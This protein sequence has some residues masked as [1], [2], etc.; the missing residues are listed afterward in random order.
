[1]YLS[2]SKYKNPAQKYSKYI[3]KPPR[4]KLKIRGSFFEK[5]DHVKLL[6]RL[7]IRTVKY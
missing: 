2:E 4:I 7:Y 6:K 5:A 3:I 1:M